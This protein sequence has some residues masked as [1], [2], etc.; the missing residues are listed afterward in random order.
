MHLLASES[1][2]ADEGASAVDLAQSPADI[3]CLSFADSD[4]AT[5]AAAWAA[6]PEPRPTLRSTDQRSSTSAVLAVK[7]LLL[8]SS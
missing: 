2:S 5:L 4:L 6:M 8:P 1:V 3:V 7:K